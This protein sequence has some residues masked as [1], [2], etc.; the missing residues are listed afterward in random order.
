MKLFFVSIQGYYPD[1]EQPYTGFEGAVLAHD[2]D[3]AIKAGLAEAIDN[4]DL[5][6]RPVRD[7]E[8]EEDEE[9]NAEL[10]ENGKGRGESGL[11]YPVLYNSD[12]A[13]VFD[14]SFAAPFADHLLS[15]IVVPG[16]GASTL[17]GFHQLEQA[18]ALLD[19]EITA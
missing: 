9:P 16:K 3:E 15:S 2:K 6:T 13:I 14:Q 1:N 11:N 19:Q 4:N 12:G 7:D 5:S 10:Q 18:Y 8:D 17:G